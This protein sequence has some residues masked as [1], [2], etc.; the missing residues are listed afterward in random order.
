MGADASDPLTNCCCARPLNIELNDDN[1]VNNPK[2][3]TAIGL[4]PKF[5]EAVIRCQSRIRMILIRKRYAISRNVKR[6][7][8]SHFS[9]IDQ[10][11]TLKGQEVE[12]DL[13]FEE[14]E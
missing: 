13:L 10:M 5:L 7:K 12:Y 11:E 8:S 3:E 1:D 2:Q 6:I 14:N 4:D 9:Y